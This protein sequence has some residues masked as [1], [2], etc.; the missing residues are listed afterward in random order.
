MRIVYYVSDHGYGHATRS[1]GLIRALAAESGGAAAIEVVNH[2]AHALLRRALAPLRGVTVVDRAT[3][4]GFVCFEDRLAY[5]VG[6]T[7]LAVNGWIAGWKRFVAEEVARLRAHPP[8][9][10]LSDV[11][12]EP[13]LVAEKLG[14]P[15]AVASN[16]TWVDQYRPHL[17]ADLVAPLLGS[18]AL[19]SRGHAY[20]MRT[21]MAGLRSVVP[22]G[23][24]TRE[25]V[26]GRAE[27]R[28]RLGVADGEPLVHLGF[29]WSADAAA[30]GSQ[31]D[32]AGLPAKVRLLVSRNLAELAS[33]PEW[34]GRI[35]TIPPDDTEAHE[36][37]AA[38]DLVVAKAGYGTIAEAIAGRVPVLAVPVEGSPESEVIARTVAELG[39]GLSYPSD[40]VVRAPVLDEA[41]QMLDDLSRYREAYRRLPPE[42]APGAAARLAR[43]I[44][45]SR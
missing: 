38:C 18:Y 45:D 6:R 29:G 24:V 42:Y 8:Q 17:R 7:A 35:L 1:I 13:L 31:L 5:D 23:L 20:P 26:L 21:A 14:A 36:Y 10:V 9:L 4:V 43:V 22:A 15:S 19:A 2:H 11:A 30:L 32:A 3:D 44:L 34:K 39:I 41:A 27:V 25:P 33:T 40:A 37:I 12:P 28:R 16:F